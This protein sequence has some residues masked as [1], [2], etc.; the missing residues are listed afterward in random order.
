M[1]PNQDFSRLVRLAVLAERLENDLRTMD[2]GDTKSGDWFYLEDQGGLLAYMPWKHDVEEQS[3]KLSLEERSEWEREGRLLARA[4]NDRAWTESLKVGGVRY[5]KP[6]PSISSPKYV[7]YRRAV[8]ARLRKVARQ[9]TKDLRPRSKQ[10][11][12]FWK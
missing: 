8:A 9:I 7:D 4:V 11:W 12:Q 1:P 2:S 3:G 10:W 6:W 5:D